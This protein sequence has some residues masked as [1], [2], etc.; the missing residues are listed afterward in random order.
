M[1][2]FYAWPNVAVFLHLWLGPEP[3]ANVWVLWIVGLWDL[4]ALRVAGYFGL[5]LALR[6]VWRRDLGV[7]HAL[8]APIGRLWFAATPFAFAHSG[9]AATLFVTLVGVAHLVFHDK[10]YREE[11]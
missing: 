8:I 10:C 6:R 9:I 11:E 5:S 4:L 3:G 7:E 2:I 1:V